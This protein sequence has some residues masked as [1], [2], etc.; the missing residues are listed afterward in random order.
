MLL[1]T[2]AEPP[3]GYLEIVYS[4]VIPL[5][6]SDVPVIFDYEIHSED[7]LQEL[8]VT[9]DDFMKECH[10]QHYYGLSYTE[11]LQNVIDELIIIQEKVVD[12]APREVLRDN[13]YLPPD[14][15]L[16]IVN[17]L[18]E[19][20]HA[21]DVVPSTS[22][23]CHN[24]RFLGDGVDFNFKGKN[25][26][27][28]VHQST[29]FE[30]IGPDRES[31][32]LSN[33]QEF[34]KIAHIVNETGT[35]NYRQAR[36]PIK[37]GLNIEAW[38]ENLSNYPDTRLIQY[39]KFGFPLSITKDKKLDGGKVTNHYSALQHPG[40]VTQYLDKERDLGAILGPV[41]D[42]DKHL[43]HCSP[44]LTRPKD[45]N[46]KCRV[47]LDLSF[48]PGQSVNDLVDKHR[49]DGYEFTFR[50][51]SI[52][53]IVGELKKYG[54]RALLA[55]IDVAR[56][57]R[58]LRV[59]PGDAL[60]FG[61]SWQG[62]ILIDTAAAF[63]WTHGAAA[64]QLVSDA[65]A[66]FMKAKGYKMFP[67]IDDYILVASE[68]VADTAFHYL[69]D[70]LVKLGLPMNS[71]KRTPP[72]KAITCLGINIDLE[73]NILSIDQEKLAAI[74]MECGQIKDKKYLT[75]RGFQS[76]LGKLLYLH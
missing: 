8:R 74:H 43:V 3:I 51:P 13:G 73:L 2:C 60:N 67:Y 15:K 30:F 28:L 23:I 57:F 16:H 52:D 31:V 46:S 56:A 45:N 44:L 11:Y 41:R 21:D 5:H 9:Y 61:I 53:D 24:S 63:G 47:I 12:T 35:S 26:G 72:T 70:V 34:L 54:S 76:L 27:H 10:F 20:Q 50:F 32:T 37:S 39:L 4:C 18:A 49:F 64:F 33:V 17:G 62:D 68:E 71:D 59:N 14:G 29:S 25:R 65:I 7:V 6:A 42:K 22:A 38:E 19:N 36:I 75:K 40:A 55:K 58:N 48:P 66:H 69:L 1:Y